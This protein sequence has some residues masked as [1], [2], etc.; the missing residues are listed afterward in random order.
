[1]HVKPMHS[2]PSYQKR[3]SWLSSTATE[4]GQRWDSS[5][6]SDLLREL[7]SG[8]ENRTLQ[9]FRNKF[10]P[11]TTPQ[12]AHAKAKNIRIFV[13]IRI[14]VYL[15]RKIDMINRIWPYDATVF[16]S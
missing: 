5:I 15:D 3:L 6:G 10:N 1:M 9:I 16:M 2:N 11:C 14:T 4:R 7:V 13:T 12:T 8:V